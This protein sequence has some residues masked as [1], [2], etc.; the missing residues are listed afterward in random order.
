MNSDRIEQFKRVDIRYTSDV[1]ILRWVTVCFLAL[2]LCFVS[3]RPSNGIEGDEIYGT[4]DIAKALRN[5]RET[6]YLRRGYFILTPGGSMTVNITGNDEQGPF[7]LKDN[8]IRMNDEKDFIVESIQ[9]DSMTLRF[10]M[11]PEN[12]FIFYLTKKPNETR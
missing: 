8:T 3:C 5:G 7:V 4:W 12:A 1:M 6:P 10:N 2:I 11:N 9:H